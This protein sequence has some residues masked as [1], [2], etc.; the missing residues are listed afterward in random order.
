MAQ[1]KI[2]EM[3]FSNVYPH[4][5]AKVEMKGRSQDELHKIISWLTVYSES[6]LQE[7]LD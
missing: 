5:L 3:S 7:A 6:T 1:H 4:Y 2:C